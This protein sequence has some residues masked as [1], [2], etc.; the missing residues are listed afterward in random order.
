MS[1]PF[2]FRFTDESVP[3]GYDEFLVPRLFN[4][5]AEALVRAMAPARGIRALDVACGPGTVDRR[6]GVRPAPTVRLVTAVDEAGFK[7]MLRAMCTGGE[8][9]TR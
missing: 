7:T 8:R 1:G 2:E 9:S 5:W 6:P 4:P 3:K